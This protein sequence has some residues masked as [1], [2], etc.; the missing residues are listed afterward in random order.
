RDLASAGGL[1]PR[2]RARRRALR[3]AT[4]RARRAP[5]RCALRRRT[6][7]R[8][9]APRGTRPSSAVRAAPGAWTRDA[10]AARAR[11][12]RGDRARLARAPPRSLV[13]TPACRAREQREPI[14]DP[15]SWEPRAGR[16]GRA[17]A[18]TIQFV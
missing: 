11:T 7:D 12:A 2:A 10:R 4:A 15:P 9:R 1:P 8:A 18:A 17:R 3:G 13:P 6:L 14:D 16:P 5:R